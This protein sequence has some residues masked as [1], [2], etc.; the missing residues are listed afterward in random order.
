M[1]DGQVLANVPAGA[2]LTD[3]IY[4]R[5]PNEPISYIIGLQAALTLKV[6][7]SQ[8]LT[9]VPLNALFTDSIYSKPA[10]EPISYNTRL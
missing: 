1:D 7:D 8:V 3:T 4:S 9:N 5:P 10:N 6:D 2:L